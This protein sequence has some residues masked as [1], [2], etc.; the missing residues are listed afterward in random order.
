MENTG[1]SAKWDNL[2]FVLIFF[3]VL[4]HILFPFRNESHAVKGLYFFIYTFHMPLFIFVSGLFSKTIIQKR[5]WKRVFSYLILYLLIR[6]IDMFG[7]LI[8]KHKLRLNFI[9]TNG[10][11]WYAL[12]IFAFLCVTIVLQNKRMDILLLASIIIGLVAGYNTHLGNQFAS[13]RICVFYPFFLLGYIVDRK[14]IEQLNTRRVRFA[15]ALLLAV[16]ILFFIM[17]GSH[18]YHMIHILKGKRTFDALDLDGAEG[19]ALRAMQYVG[20]V[21]IGGLVIL[22]VPS[23]K[24]NLSYIGA[25]TLPIYVWH[26][27]FLKFFWAGSGKNKVLDAFPDTYGLVLIIMCLFLIYLCSRKPFEKTKYI[28]C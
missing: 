21:V 15:A 10:P 19:L 27:L 4:G 1:R 26:N 12:A 20:S 6:T 8:E 5:Q 22:M 18:F 28:M 25:K 23:F 3:V 16:I 7:T 24:T 2:K 14:K 9:K 11:D 17:K 13:M